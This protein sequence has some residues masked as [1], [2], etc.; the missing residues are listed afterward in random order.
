MFCKLSLSKAKGLSKQA[1]VIGQYNSKPL[2]NFDDFSLSTDFKDIKQFSNQKP[3]SFKFKI[4][5]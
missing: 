2:T 4:L 1:Q 3:F 5:P